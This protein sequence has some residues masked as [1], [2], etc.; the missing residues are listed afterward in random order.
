MS[1]NAQT[2]NITMADLNAEAAPYQT[3]QS[4][5]RRSAPIPREQQKPYPCAQC[6]ELKKRDAMGWYCPCFAGEVECDTCGNVMRGG[7]FSTCRPC[8]RKSRAPREPRDNYN[9]RP[10]NPQPYPCDHCNQLKKRDPMG[11]YCPCVAGESECVDCKSVMR[12]GDYDRCRP[13]YRKYRAEN[14]SRGW[15]N[16]NY[17][18]N[19]NGYVPRRPRGPR[20]CETCQ[21]PL[22]PDR[23]CA[24]CDKDRLRN[25][26]Y[27]KECQ[28][29]T[30][31][32]NASKG[33]YCWKHWPEVRAYLA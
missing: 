31:N 21:N 3:F 2:N 29:L 16:P 15:V 23:Y 25:C 12:G 24:S 5:Y 8:Y 28:R 7:K 33:H 18:E 6:N 1:L 14:P 17:N 4:T 30:K 10:Y 11:W 19:G 13:C 26:D 22:H 20:L 9:R 32:G 27:D